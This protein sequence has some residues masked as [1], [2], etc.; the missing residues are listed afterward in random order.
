MNYRLL[1]I[2][3]D[4]TLKQEPHPIS[5][6]NKEAIVTTPS[7]PRL[8]HTSCVPGLPWKY[9]PDFIWIT[10][11]Q[12]YDYIPPN[13]KCKVIYDCMD[14]STGFDFPESFKSKILNL[15]EKLS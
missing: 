14:L 5:E 6:A 11:P 4:G 1:F 15:E 10:F 9:D 7:D 12:L 8:L 13:T 3:V 2:D